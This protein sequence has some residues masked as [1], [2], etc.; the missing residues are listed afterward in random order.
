MR[1]T[2][3]WLQGGRIVRSAR[4]QMPMDVGKLVAEQF[5][6]DLHGLPRV[7]EHRS[8][9]GHFFDE[10]AAFVARKVEEFS[11]MTF[12]YQHGPAGEELV[13][14]Q[15]GLGQSTIGNE[16]VPIGPGSDTGF[17]RLVVHG[18]LRAWASCGVIRP[19]FSKSWINLSVLALLGGV[20]AVEAAFFDLGGSRFCP[21]TRNEGVKTAT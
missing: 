8:H 6:V 15:I 20:A 11:R 12:Q 3:H 16:S 5:I 13:V 21:I 10:S 14:V 9:L 7:C 18:W 2:P 19:F 17:A 1:N 4:N